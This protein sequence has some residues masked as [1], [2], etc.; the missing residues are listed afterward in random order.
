MSKTSVECSHF[1]TSL[2]YTVGINYL[3]LGE[4]RIPCRQS[5]DSFSTGTQLFGT[6]NH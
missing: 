6:D 2:V 3:G 1:I 5:E 4:S